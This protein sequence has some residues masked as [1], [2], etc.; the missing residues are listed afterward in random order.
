MNGYPAAYVLTLAVEPPLCALAA[1]R[2]VGDAWRGYRAGL[3]GNATSHPFTWLVLYPWL[4]GHAPSTAAFAAAE[5]VAVAWEAAVLVALLR[6]EPALL[7]ALAFVT[8]A[9]SLG[10]GVLLPR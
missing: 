9:V 4:S 6:R 10:L 3:V 8:N 5:A 1:R 7:V 2:L